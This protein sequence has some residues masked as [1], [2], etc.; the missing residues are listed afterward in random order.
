MVVL[1]MRGCG[2]AERGQESTME[3][4]K[5]EYSP[6]FLVGIVMAIDLLRT[7]SSGYILY[8][9]RVFH[10]VRQKKEVKKQE[11]LSAKLVQEIAF[12]DESDDVQST[13][14]QV[15]KIFNNNVE[16]QDIVLD[17]NDRINRKN[18]RDVMTRRTKPDPIIKVRCTKPKNKSLKLY[19]IR[20]KVKF[21]YTDVALSRELVKF[22]YNEWMQ[23]LEIIDQHKGVHAQEVKLAVQHLLNK[24]KKLNLVPSVGLSASSYRLASSGRTGAP[25]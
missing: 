11:R 9:T 16:K 8:G 19:L 3:A 6:F 7:P 2:G 1:D 10:G 23:I 25:K 13:D 22:C 24:L 12:T 21:S 5:E 17:L 14:N 15:K 4:L 18:F 20:K